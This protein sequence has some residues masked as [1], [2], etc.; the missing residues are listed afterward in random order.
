[1]D[2]VKLMNR[3]DTKFLLNLTELE[4]ILKDIKPH[5]SVLEVKGN[6]M[7]AYE[8]LY[9]DTPDYQFYHDHHNG[10]TSRHKVRYRRYI[11]SDLCFLEVKHKY[12][13]R[14]NKQRIRCK[15]IEEQM[16]EG[17]K[18]FIKASSNLH[19]NIVPSIWNS[20]KRATL[21]NKNAPERMT[22]D[23]NLTYY[24]QN[25]KHT[26]DALVIVELK[27]EYVDRSSPF[28]IFAKRYGIRPKSISKYCIGMIF[29]NDTL[30]YNNFKA[31]LLAI[32]K[33]K[34]GSTI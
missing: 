25:W 28:M 17:S 1:M 26:E 19:Q 27:Q 32:E 7:S 18:T 9:Y 29:K 31:K 4:Q 11:E 24:W 21:V 30:K 14:T 16:S 33:T 12:K 34:H 5:Y 8:S 20:F 3:T 10:R 23:F 6:R 22:I 15:S 2:A 13:G